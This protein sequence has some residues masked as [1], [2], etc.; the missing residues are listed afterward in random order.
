MFGKLVNTKNLN[1]KLTEICGY[2][3]SKDIFP[4]ELSSGIVIA[5]FGE[6]D[7]YPSVMAYLIEGVANNRLK[8][9]Q[10]GETQI[11]SDMTAAIVPFAQHKMVYTFMEGIH[12]DYRLCLEG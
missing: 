7:I 5:G 4:S 10:T 1:I 6:S 3:F 2:L 12:P 8:Y 9:K 11:S